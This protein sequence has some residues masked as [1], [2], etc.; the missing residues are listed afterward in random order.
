MGWPRAFFFFLKR[1][2]E[3]SQ[4]CATRVSSHQ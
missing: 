2:D 3:L 4:D 1:V